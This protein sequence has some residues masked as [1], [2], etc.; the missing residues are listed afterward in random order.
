MYFA[1]TLAGGRSLGNWYPLKPVRQRSAT[2]KAETGWDDVL[3][4][5]TEENPVIDYDTLV[6]S[7][8]RMLAGFSP[9]DRDRFFWK[10]AVAFYRLSLQTAET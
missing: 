9:T 4:D 8:D 3:Q 1:I 7:L 5:L 6:A 2:G 10:N